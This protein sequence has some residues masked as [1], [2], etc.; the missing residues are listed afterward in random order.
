VALVAGAG[1]PA[2]GVEYG[3]ECVELGW[4]DRFEADHGWRREPWQVA[5]PDAQATSAF[6]SDGGVFGI[7]V[8]DRAMAW[9]RTINPVW[10]ADFPFLE[11]EYET[12]GDVA[13]GPLIGIS[14]GS[15]G[16]VTPGARNP[17]NPLASGAQAQLGPAAPGKH[18]LVIDLR[19]PFKS[20]RVARITLLLRSGKQPA[21]L[22]VRR[23]AFWATDPRKPAAE[24]P[25]GRSAKKLLAR[26]RAKAGDDAKRWQPVTLPT[27]RAISADWLGRAYG[28]AGHWRDDRQFHKGGVS[29]RLGTAEHAALATGVM[30]TGGIEVAGDRRGCELALLL[31]TRVFGSDIP[32]YSVR[33]C[34]PRGPIRSPHRL[35]VRLEYK[36]GTQRTHFP[37]SLADKAFSVARRPQPYV[38]PLDP[39][40]DLVGFDVVDE[41]NFGQVFLLAASVN[42]SSHPVGTSSLRDRDVVD[43]KHQPEPAP[44]QTHSTRKADALT[45]ENTWVRLAMNIDRGLGVREMTLVPYD[46]EIVSH[47]E[48][49]S[50]VE[51]RDEQDRPTALRL[52]DCRVLREAA[53]TLFSFAWTTRGA[54]DGR[55][56]QLD[57]RVQ[58]D[59]EIHLTPALRNDAE[60]PWPLT[61]VAPQLRGC[62][63][64]ASPEDRHYLLGTRSTALGNEP[65]DRTDRYGGGYPLQLMDIFAPRAGGGL[66]VM[67]A[68][69]QLH[70]KTFRFKQDGQGADLSVR[71]PDVIVPP[72]GRVT[73]P[74][75]ILMP[76]A[77]DW[78]APYRRY[79]AWARAARGATIGNRLADLFYCRRDYPAGGTGYLFNLRKNHYTPEQ[80]IDESTRAL[81]GIDMIDISGWAHNEATGRVGDY[82]KNDLGGLPELRRAVEAAHARGVKVGLYFEGYLLDRR[83][84]PAESALP[85]W[86]L[87]RKDG[88]GKW[89]KGEMEFFACPGVKAWRETLSGMVA[90]VARETGADAV[91]VDQLGFA[92]AGKVCWSPDHGHPVPS[93]PMVEEQRMLRAVRDAL[94]RHTPRTGI[95]LEQMP[96]DVLTGL[97]DG[98]FNYGMNKAGMPRHATKLPL[99][100]FVFPEVAVIEMVG[101]GI[102]PVPIGA[103]DL[104]RCV[105]HGLA[106]WLKG[107]SASWHAPGF[108]DVAR[109]AHRILREHH[110]AFRSP[111]CE[112]HVPTL[113]TSVYANR[114]A[115]KSKTIVTLYNAGYSD[116]SGDLVQIRAPTGW[117]VHDAW[118][119]RPADVRREG[120][121][122]IIRGRLEPH[123]VGVFLL[124]ES[125]E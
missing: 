80:L 70:A 96:C 41:M 102:R 28:T 118:L 62:V 101:H 63:I 78:R 52:R 12:T 1:A 113:C 18:H 21:R 61:L 69:T 122:V 19:E 60:S 112:P 76:H 24:A 100:R 71:Y 89:W 103:A 67:V 33:S 79:R 13:D 56:L 98:A 95:Y 8:A 90:D 55:E 32:W 117:R 94:D 26:D 31:A 42:G 54:A 44:V 83:S 48:P 9:T 22:T 86:Q 85:A 36:D 84:E 68:D 92:D 106:V 59:G 115:T 93:N 116:V 50:L 66:G 16:P 91:Y 120:K 11:A 45:V 104:H 58:D 43:A 6:G 38:V 64:A 29:F 30:E 109:R 57:L 7:T 105:F 107:R 14:D 114:F 65:I 2:A 3:R 37:W 123:S 39:T 35:A 82:R 47:A 17:E 49:I 73:L 75:A 27:A 10:T 110:D 88:S 40:K 111:D 15:T 51:V 121:R 23:L 119:D 53:G 97:V 46:R 124:T 4:R 20:D 108:R 77:G 99:H 74:T 34:R 5:S 125:E 87:V 81:G 25:K 72:H